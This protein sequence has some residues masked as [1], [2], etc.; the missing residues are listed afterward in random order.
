M[1]GLRGLQPL[2]IRPDWCLQFVAVRTYIVIPEGT[3]VLRVN[4]STPHFAINKAK[5]GKCEH[6]AGGCVAVPATAAI[7]AHE[8]PVVIPGQLHLEGCP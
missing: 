5:R 7:E 8:R 1:T 2:V 4:A 3:P 6:V